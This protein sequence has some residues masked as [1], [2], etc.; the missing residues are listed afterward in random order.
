MVYQKSNVAWT[1]DSIFICNYKTQIERYLE[2]RSYFSISWWKSCPWVIAFSPQ[3]KHT[4]IVVVQCKVDKLI[5]IIF[6]CNTDFATWGMT[7]GFFTLYPNVIK[8]TS[9]N[10]DWNEVLWNVTHKEH[11]KLEMCLCY[12]LKR[13][14]K[15]VFCTTVL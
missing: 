10:H 14:K 5:R 2:S 7:I 11:T 13:K 4:H 15:G 8:V 6:S 9:R 12:T 3:E 1:L